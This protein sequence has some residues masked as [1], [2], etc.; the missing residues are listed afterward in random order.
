VLQTCC[1]ATPRK[2]QRRT[3][4]FSWVNLPLNRGKFDAALVKY[5]T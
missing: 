3:N 4:T 2:S 5:E 1:A